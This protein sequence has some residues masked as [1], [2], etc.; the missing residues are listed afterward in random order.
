MVKKR[1]LQ[2]ADLR[3]ILDG[4]PD[5]MYVYLE[6]GTEIGHLVGHDPDDCWDVAEGNALLL[7][8]EDD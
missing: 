4:L 2:V 5:D 7:I 1:F 3:R 6:S 8:A